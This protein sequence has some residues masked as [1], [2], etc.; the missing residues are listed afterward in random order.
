MAITSA[1]VLYAVF[2]FMTFFI[3]LPI[4]VQ[5]QGDKGEIVPGTHAGA[6]EVHNLKKKAWITTAV[7]SVLWAITVA[8]IL[9]GVITVRDLDWFNRMPPLE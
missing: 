7:A 9:S 8:I 1:I 6:P 3:A 4:R 5:T 2:W